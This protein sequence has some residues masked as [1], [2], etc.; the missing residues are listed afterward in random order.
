MT[1]Q[2]SNIW[3]TFQRIKSRIASLFWGQWWKIPENNG[4]DT[5]FIDIDTQKRSWGLLTSLRF[6][7][8]AMKLCW[9][10]FTYLLLFVYG[11]LNMLEVQG[12]QEINCAYILFSSHLRSKKFSTYYRGRAS[13]LSRVTSFSLTFRWFKVNRLKSCG[14][15]NF[16]GEIKAH[17]SGLLIL[18]YR[19]QNSALA[20]FAYS[21]N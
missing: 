3:Q 15:F 12:L 2:N 11:T 9:C 21:N 13:S 18:W 7:H 5:D 10:F 4:K 20:C 6:W 16:K 14:K 17:Q 1:T 8:F 19:I